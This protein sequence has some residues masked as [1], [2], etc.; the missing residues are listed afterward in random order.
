MNFEPTRA[1][2]PEKKKLYAALDG[3]QVNIPARKVGIS[4]YL[5]CVLMMAQMRPF[6]QEL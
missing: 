1:D 5:L 4:C 3:L 6:Y 2:G